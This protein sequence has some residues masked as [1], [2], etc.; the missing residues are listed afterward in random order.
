MDLNIA[1]SSKCPIC[2][3]D[4]F[5]DGLGRRIN[6]YKCSAVYVVRD[7]LVEMYIVLIKVQARKTFVLMRDVIHP[8]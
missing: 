5:D 3:F 2:H 7:G 4:S 1:F 6:C 8:S